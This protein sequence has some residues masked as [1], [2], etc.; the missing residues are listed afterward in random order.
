M[1]HEAE[2]GERGRGGA[3]GSGQGVLVE[4][5]VDGGAHAQV[6]AVLVL[7][8]QPQ[9][10][11]AVPSPPTHRHTYRHTASIQTKEKEG[12]HVQTQRNRVGGPER[13]SSRKHRTRG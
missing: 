9:D 11:G 5:V 8:C 10:V 12:V 7:Q 4:A 13:D 3:R 6:R 1:R 2:G